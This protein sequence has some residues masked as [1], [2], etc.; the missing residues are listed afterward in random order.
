[1]STIKELYDKLAKLESVEDR[2][3]Y[4]QCSVK[5]YS[6]K[7][8]IE[9]EEFDKFLIDVIGLKCSGDRKTE[10]FPLMTQNAHNLLY[11][12]IDYLTTAENFKEINDIICKDL[13]EILVEKFKDGKIFGFIPETYTRLETRRKCGFHG[14]VF[15]DEI[16]TQ[17]RRKKIR[18]E[19]L[20]EIE[21]SELGEFIL[22]KQD[23]LYQRE[24]DIKPI[25]HISQIIDD[26]VLLETN[27][28]TIIPFAKKDQN[29]RDYRLMFKHNVDRNTE[30]LLLKPTAE[31]LLM[32]EKQRQ[33]RDPSDIKDFNELRKS[34]PSELR[35]YVRAKLKEVHNDYSP[36]Y[37]T[38]LKHSEMFLFDCMAGL[39]SMCKEHYIIQIF[40]KGS[41]AKNNTF[42][43]KLLKFYYATYLMTMPEVETELLDYMVDILYLVLSPLFIRGNKTD[44]EKI[45]VDLRSCI[46][47]FDKPQRSDRSRGNEKSFFDTVTSDYHESYRR[48]RVHTKDD[49]PDEEDFKRHKIVK[50]ILRSWISDFVV[51]IKENIY[52]SN[53]P[54]DEEL[55]HGD[56]MLKREIEPF[57]IGFYEREI[58]NYSFENL[59][60]DA[61]NKKNY[62]C[63]IRNLIK[64]M[65]LCETWESGFESTDSIIVKILS[66]LT[67]H[68]IYATK[69]SNSGKKV[70]YTI[71]IYNIKQSHS[72]ESLPYNQW[73]IDNSD[74]LTEWLTNLY[75]DFIEPLQDESSFNSVGGLGHI[76]RLIHDDHQLR[77]QPGTSFVP[78]KDSSRNISKKRDDPR[79][80][81]VKIESNI[82]QFYNH[83]VGRMNPKVYEPSDRNCPYFSVRNGII[84]YKTINNGQWTY[85][86]TTD[87]RDIILNAYTL[88]KYEPNY[89]YEEEIAYREL[90]KILKDI[91]PDAQDYDYMMNLFSTAF[92]PQIF[93][94]QLLF[95]FGTGSDGKSTMS[96]LLGTILG[97][98]SGELH[99]LDTDNE[100]IS[101]K[102]PS[103][104]CSSFKPQC[105]QESQNSGNANEGGIISFDRKT[106]VIA[107]EPPKGKIHSEIVKDFTSGGISNGRGLYQGNKQF[108]INTLCIIETNI[109]PQFDQID[110][111]IKRRVIVYK[112]NTKF[113]SSATNSYK[114]RRKENVK[115]ANSESI[116][117]IL[118]DTS[119][120]TA[121]LMMML[122][123]VIKLRN[124]VYKDALNPNDVVY[125][126]QLSHIPK[127]YNVKMFT[128][129]VFGKT[130]GVSKYLQEN[131]I[132][133]S[134][135][136]AIF[137]NDLIDRIIKEDKRQK[138]LKGAGILETSKPSMNEKK[139][140]IKQI[141]QNVYAD[142]LF[143]IRREL[144]IRDSIKDDGLF[145][146]DEN[147]IN[148]MKEAIMKLKVPEIVQ[149][150]T[151]GF[152]MET[153]E[154]GNDES[155]RDVIIVGVNFNDNAEEEEGEM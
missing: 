147:K 128:S 144:A 133:N 107:Q 127:P 17:N 81:V 44:S 87:N 143:M 93:K 89:K 53:N 51:F 152:S 74:Y 68:Y 55:S 52:Q 79:A 125:V 124:T 130:T 30:S 116:N 134:E 105:L 25:E 153:I 21:N 138:T 58:E 61:P 97:N 49:K 64:L 99:V 103:G 6:K 67:S 126:S 119:Y 150:L 54:T 109:I 117:N 2:V 102:N 57:K 132:N 139:N 112:H 13:M 98:T 136:G 23:V 90:E 137:L 8:F 142:D 66:S 95:A 20:E 11:V 78:G 14:F 35:E 72:L 33:N 118:Q 62:N 50:K 15:C 111:A 69:D 1:M 70:P 121:M 34:T 41:W 45:K 122:R 26:Q 92:C 123:R 96:R 146:L 140:E 120:W 85:D 114:N 149:K 3:N 19:L 59:R 151:D 115:I 43:F 46:E 27:H 82:I 12:D 106:F 37:P 60:V 76:L 71:Y 16:L 28:S 110:E 47:Y 56:R 83:F 145:K 36:N 131:L 88:A 155:Y 42:V 129:N 4:I 31:E 38:E 24:T 94:D 101:L 154:D 108:V 113:I 75:T 7:R 100:Q 9:F 39:A 32:C 40:S 63:Q 18:E 29:S 135:Y 22:S 86:F 80:F 141:I 77:T 91:Y 104:Y 10:A 148:G 5:G 84:R 73:I 65:I 48:V